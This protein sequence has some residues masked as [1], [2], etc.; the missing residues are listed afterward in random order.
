MLAGIPYVMRSPNKN[1]RKYINIHAVDLQPTTIFHHQGINIE[2]VASSNQQRTFCRQ[3][4]IP[5]IAQQQSCHLIISL[6]AT[7]K[8]PCLY[9]NS[10]TILPPFVCPT[11]PSPSF[12]VVVVVVALLENM[13]HSFVILSFELLCRRQQS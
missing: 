9:R 1:R 8:K 11:E 6:A 12:I 13:V 5:Q 3:V 2:K 10:Q 7:N 4:N